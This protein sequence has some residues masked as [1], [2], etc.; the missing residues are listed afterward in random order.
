MLITLFFTW[1]RKLSSRSHAESSAPAT[2]FR[3]MESHIACLQRC[4]Q[5]RTAETYRATLNS[6]S[7]FRRGCDLR[8]DEFVPELVSD[9]E[10]YLKRKGLCP[11]T[12][13]FYLKRL[14][15]VYNQAADDGLVQDCRP[16]RKVSVTTE[17]TTKRALTLSAIR[18]IRLMDLYESPSKRKARDLFLLSFYL[19]GMSFVDMAHLR[20]KDLRNGVLTYR[21]QKTGQLLTIRWEPCMEHLASRYAAPSSSPYLLSI[22]ADAD[23]DT[24]RQYQSALAS[25]NRHLHDLGRSLRLQ[26]PLTMYVARHSWATIARKEGIPLSVI[27]EGMGH[28][29]ENT[30]QIYLASLEA[31]VIDEANR[32]ILSRLGI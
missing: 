10:T 24:R 26:R 13:V 14:R 20:K 11:N 19:R 7:R 15:S 1:V 2:W 6:F 32:K 21:R 12:I 29:S 5:Y 16:F 17:K 18:R 28:D 30:T 4:G 31:N 27:S 9:Y 3:Y 23:G 25:V 8:L 22:I